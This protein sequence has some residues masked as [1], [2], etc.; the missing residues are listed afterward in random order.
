MSELGGSYD[1]LDDWSRLAAPKLV[2]VCFTYTPTC[3]IHWCANL[4]EAII[5]CFE[6]L[7]PLFVKM[8]KQAQEMIQDWPKVSL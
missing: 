3:V 6:M 8:G 5:S 2:E 7:K 4:F 1:G